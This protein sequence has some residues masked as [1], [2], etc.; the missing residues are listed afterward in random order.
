MPIVFFEGF[1][2]SDSDTFKLDTKYWSSNKTI[3]M[4]NGAGRTGHSVSLLDRPS[5]SGLS[6]NTTLTLS[7]FNDPLS[8]S[9]GIGIGFCF[10]YRSIMTR[11]QNISSSPHNENLISFY[12]NSNSEVLR[13]DIIR[14]S[15]TYG[16]SMG[17]G[18]YQNSSLVDTYDFKSHIGHS[19]AINNTNSSNGLYYYIGQYNTFIEIYIDAKS[20]QKISLKFS[21]NTTYNAPLR[22]TNN[23]LETNINGFNSLK[24]ITF[25]SKHN[26]LEGYTLIDDLYLSAGNSPSEALLGQNTRIYK[27]SLDSNYSPIQWSSY[28][29]NSNGQ[30]VFLNSND[31]D[32]T[33]A[34]SETSGNTSI[35]ELSNLSSTPNNVGGIKIDNIVRSSDPTAGWN[36]VNVLSSGAA[37]IDDV[38]I[39]EVSSTTYSNKDTFIFTNP[40]AGSGVPW[41]LSDINNLKVG[42]KNLGSYTT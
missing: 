27:L 14:T 32:A 41:T 26:S 6:A 33:Y 23:Q 39:H 34:R 38:K 21:G 18:I 20:Q 36:M 8:I 12:D 10:P 24:S 3:S 35:F 13:L 5:A 29:G 2:N 30:S 15:G 25:Y 40:M 9:N 28:N 17:I 4:S 1:N 19:W 31:G 22:N 42:I 16:D 37:I 7:N 11:P